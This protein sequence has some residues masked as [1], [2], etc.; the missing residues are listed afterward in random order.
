MPAAHRPR[1]RAL[2]R[3]ES[4]T[5]L[6]RRHAGVIAAWDF[7]VG[8]GAA[9]GSAGA[10]QAGPPGSSS[11]GDRGER[12][13]RVLDVIVLDPERFDVVVVEPASGAVPSGLRLD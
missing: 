6:T 10:Q 11:N 12:S 1:R 8:R 5:A 4:R 9:P 7:R 13:L 3:D 2:A